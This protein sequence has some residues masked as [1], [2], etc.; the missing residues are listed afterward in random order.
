MNRRGTKYKALRLAAVANVYGVGSILTSNASDF[1]RYSNHRTRSGIAALII[2][3]PLQRG[4]AR[5]PSDR[6]PRE[7]PRYL[8]GGVISVTGTS[9][10]ANRISNLLCSSRL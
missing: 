8:L 5:T 7:F 2:A 9:Q 3:L 10:C 4:H 1:M 6:N